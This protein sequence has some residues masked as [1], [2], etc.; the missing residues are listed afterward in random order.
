MNIKL[1]IG[2][3]VLVALIG[4]GC[5]YVFS[6]SE[7]QQATA[8]N[9]Q[10]T[11]CFTDLGVTS[12]LTVDGASTLTGTVT[13]GGNATLTGDV[14]INGGNGALVLTT[15]NAATSTAQIGCIQTTATSTATPVILV[16]SSTA[17]TSPTF[18]AG[19][20]VGGVFWKFG[21]CPI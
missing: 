3:A 20:A 6:H 14:T 2:L 7:S 8:V 17:S 1:K 21:T 5:F 19:T 18:G 12:T 16:L 9:C 15:T 10:T 13:T 11:T 4:T